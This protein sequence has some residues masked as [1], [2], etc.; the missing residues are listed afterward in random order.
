MVYV[1]QDGTL[2]VIGHSQLRP[3]LRFHECLLFQRCESKESS[4]VAVKVLLQANAARKPG[5][6]F[7][8]TAAIGGGAAM[9]LALKTGTGVGL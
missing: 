4:V 1:W 2:Y 5:L 3:C 8:L 7:V 9:R 6:R